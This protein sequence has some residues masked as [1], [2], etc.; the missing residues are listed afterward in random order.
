[1]TA[2]TAILCTNIYPPAGSNEANVASRSPY[3]G[4]IPRRV[5]L[6]EFTISSYTTGGETLPSAGTLGL[7]EITSVTAQLVGTSVTTFNSVLRWDRTNGKLIS[8][9]DVTPG[10]QTVST[11][12]IGTVMLTIIGY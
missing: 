11:S 5:I 7:T 8:V 10:T 9:G 2:T 1:M 4:N 3:S 12:N 6:V